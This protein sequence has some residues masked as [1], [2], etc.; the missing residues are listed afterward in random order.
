MSN[1]QIPEELKGIEKNKFDL[2]FATGAGGRVY[3]IPTDIAEQYAFNEEHAPVI[4][5]EELRKASEND[6]EVQ[7]HHAVRLHD[8][9]IGYHADWAT[10]YYIW[11]ADGCTYYG[12]HHHPF[13]WTNPLAKDMDDY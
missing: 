6:D 1:T 2:V 8:G 7:G 3:A 13:G 12:P 5:H 10:G 9:T 4:G 11:W